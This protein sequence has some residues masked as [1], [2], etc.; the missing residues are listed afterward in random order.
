MVADDPMGRHGPK[1]DKF[2]Q[3]SNMPSNQNTTLKK[4]V[5][6][7]PQQQQ[8]EQ[9]SSIPLI[10]LTSSPST[11]N[12]INSLFQST[13]PLSSKT[14]MNQIPPD[15]FFRFASAFF[16]LTQTSTHPPQLP[17]D[18]FNIQSSIHHHP[19]PLILLPP[20][21]PQEQQKQLNKRT[22]VL[23]ENNKQ[24]KPNEPQQ[25]QKR[26]PLMPNQNF[27]NKNF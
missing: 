23:K 11:H 13:L 12:D 6:Q 10:D 21:Q 26:S 4:S 8:E 2:L 20:Q 19:I 16:G 15:Q 24:L 5:H 9:H 22:V 25:N 17:K 7:R 14:H 27:P 1:L 18:L 3:R